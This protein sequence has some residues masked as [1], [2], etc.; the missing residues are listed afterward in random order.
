MNEVL[1]IVRE[2][3]LTVRALEFSRQSVGQRIVFGQVVTKIEARLLVRVR[4]RG[5]VYLAEALAARFLRHIV[6]CT[7]R[8]RN[9][10]A[11]G[12]GTLQHFHT[13][14]AIRFFLHAGP[15]ATYHQAIAIGEGRKAANLDVVVALVRAV[16]I[17]G[18][19]SG[20]LHHLFDAIGLALFDFLGG[21]HRDRRRRG[22]DFARHLA[23]G[24]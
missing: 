14:K 20:I 9:A 8:I 16:V 5:A 1:I 24:T 23:D 4:A 3:E 21:H 19:A 13:L 2:V 17:G 15:G 6:D 22:E 12:V 7:T 10:K 11:R 18:Y